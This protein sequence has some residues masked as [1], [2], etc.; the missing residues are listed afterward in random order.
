MDDIQNPQ[1]QTQYQP[2]PQS[3]YQQQQYQQQQ[4]QQQ[5]YQQPQYQQPYGGPMGY[6]PRPAVNI[7][8]SI[9]RWDFKAMSYIAVGMFFLSLIVCGLT[10]DRTT[11]LLFDFFS[12]ASVVLVSF[13][14]Y[15]Q[16]APKMEEGNGV[17]WPLLIGGIVALFLGFIIV[18]IKAEDWDTIKTLRTVLRISLVVSAFSLLYAFFK[19]NVFEHSLPGFIIGISSVIA[20]MGHLIGEEES[21]GSLCVRVGGI[22]LFSAMVVLLGEVVYNRSLNRG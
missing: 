2:Q 8:E 13:I 17:G 12:L 22:G 16:A 21:F 10:K 3:Q 19:V 14:V 6:A 9:A 15:A 11:Y 1:E 7:W 20:M 18:F 4:Y 5:Q